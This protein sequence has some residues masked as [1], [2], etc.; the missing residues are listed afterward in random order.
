MIPGRGITKPALVAALVIFVTLLH[1]C[2][3]MSAHHYHIF[4]Q[5]L[6]FVPLILSVFWFSLNGA[7]LTSISISVLY[8]SFILMHW[9]GF[10][11]EDFGRLLEVILY[12][13][14]AVC[15]GIMR[16]RELREQERLRAAECLAAM[17][18]A[19]S[20]V[21]HDMKTPL[22]AIGG[23]SSLILKHLAGHHDSPDQEY[24]LDKL[25]IIIRE[26]RRLEDLVKEMLDFSRPLELHRSS[27]DIGT[28]VEESIAVAQ[29]AA[30]EKRVTIL[31]RS[32]SE[33]CLV[34]VDPLRM[35][36][37]LINLLTNAVQASP[38]DEMV[39]VKYGKDRTNLFIDVVDHGCGVTPEQ[40][41]E[42][43]TPFYTTK[44]EGTGLGL[45]IVKKIV[46]AHGGSVDILESAEGGLTFRVIL[47]CGEF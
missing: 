12:N 6:Y 10:S 18:K 15:M 20:G 45:P 9:A 33:V 11:A 14:F 47:P 17:G 19:L 38:E 1:F 30:L 28:I 3:A 16:N 32:Q 40:R 37:V 26:T 39:E 41:E 4:Y 34:C 27:G 43:F 35:K 13:T 5:E 21:A 31:N 25:G 23:F 22:I 36:Q 44:K 8:L 7:M 29:A 42:L 2:T 46:E 24:C